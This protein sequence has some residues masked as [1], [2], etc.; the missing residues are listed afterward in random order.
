MD[1][2]HTELPNYLSLY[3]HAYLPFYFLVRRGDIGR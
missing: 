3:L 1:V 2:E